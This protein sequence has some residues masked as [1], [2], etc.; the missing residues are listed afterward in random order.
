MTGV[1]AAVCWLSLCS[2]PG[3]LWSGAAISSEWYLASQYMSKVSKEPIFPMP[4]V[5]KQWLVDLE[6][7]MRESS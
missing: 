3:A 6:N 7:P 1:G 4:S 5:V 2:S